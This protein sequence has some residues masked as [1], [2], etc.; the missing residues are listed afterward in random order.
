MMKIYP[1]HNARDDDAGYTAEEIRKGIHLVYTDVTCQVCGKEQPLAVTDN[2]KCCKCGG[3]T[4]ENTPPTTSVHNNL[5]SAIE[6]LNLA[7]DRQIPWEHPCYER[8]DG[9]SPMMKWQWDCWEVANAYID[10]RNAPGL[11]WTSKLVILV[12]ECIS[13]HRNGMA[14]AS[15]DAVVEHWTKQEQGR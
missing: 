3:R 9:R 1:K 4:A 15:W 12:G 6:R 13:N 11:S 5:S 14:S 2:G 7:R 10:R 8:T